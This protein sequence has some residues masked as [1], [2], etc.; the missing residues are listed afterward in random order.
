MP[1]GPHDKKGQDKDHTGGSPPAHVPQSTLYLDIFSQAPVEQAPLEELLA[2]DAA[3]AAP[4]D[5][6]AEAAELKPS[7]FQRKWDELQAE[8]REPLERI[9]R[10]S[11]ASVVL[12]ARNCL[13]RVRHLPAFSA[14][15]NVREPFE[16]IEEHLAVII[17]LADDAT[18]G[19]Y[20]DS[21]GFLKE[22]AKARHAFT[23]IGRGEESPLMDCAATLAAT[24]RSLCEFNYDSLIRYCIYVAVYANLAAT[25]TSEGG[26]DLAK[27][28]DACVRDEVSRIRAN[29][30]RIPAQDAGSLEGATIERST[31][32][33]L[34][35]SPE[36]ERFM[37]R[38]AG[39]DARAADVRSGRAKPEALTDPMAALIEAH[40]ALAESRLPLTTS[41]AAKYLGVSEDWVR[42][43][44]RKGEIGE[45]IAGEYRFHREQLAA[46][47]DRER[48]KGGRPKGPR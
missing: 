7:R 18:F 44:A 11:P 6:G 47:K 48:D 22:V 41:E 42:K 27:F 5:E 24:I 37:E 32:E 20:R 36:E 13:E 38:L 33:Q 23:T 19:R 2:P 12:I 4:P 40:R 29:R 10:D 28:V 3:A 1:S 30:E 15:T 17:K 21:A 35:L 8:L 43:M 45:C 9:A 39:L 26:E 31:V 14:G 34:R 25:H 16:D 46:H